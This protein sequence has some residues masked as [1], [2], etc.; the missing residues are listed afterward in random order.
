M[1]TSA[2]YMGGTRRMQWTKPKSITAVFAAALLLTAC[3]SGANEQTVS[4]S[5]ESALTESTSAA[6][7]VSE[8]SSGYDNAIE[9]EYDGRITQLMDAFAGKD[10]E[11]LRML[12]SADSTSA[13]DF[14]DG[15]DISGYSIISSEINAGSNPSDFSKTYHISVNVTESSDDRFKAGENVWTVTALDPLGEYSFFGALSIGDESRESIRLLERSGGVSDKVWFCYQ[16][17][18]ELE[19]YIRYTEPIAKDEDFYSSYAR[20]LGKF[21]ESS[22]DNFNDAAQK[23]FGIDAGFDDDNIQPLWYGAYEKE[24]SAAYED[25]NEV[26]IDF[27]ADS[28]LLTKACTVKFILDDTDGYIRLDGTEVTYDSGLKIASYTT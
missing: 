24:A 7:T 20:F 28:L 9:Q 6:D 3:G 23:Y 13:F 8:T 12:C 16:C 10:K 27:Y 19:P 26:I 5:A 18:V 2:G 4:S 15:V 1:Y 11:T 14:I 17:M 21:T 25:E 22:A